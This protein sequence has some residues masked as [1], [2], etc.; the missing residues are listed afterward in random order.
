MIAR[1]QMLQRGLMPYVVASQPIPILAIAPIKKPATKA[2]H[3]AD[4]GRKAI[5]NLRKQGLDV[6]WQELRKSVVKLKLG[7]E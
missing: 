3:R 5:A 6:K 7:G 1:F 2:S 4:L